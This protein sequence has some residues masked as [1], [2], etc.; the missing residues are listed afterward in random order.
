M[1]VLEQLLGLWHRKNKNRQ[2]IPANFLL[3]KAH[4]L[5]DFKNSNSKLIQKLC[6]FPIQ[7]F[8]RTF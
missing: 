5:Q 7:A 6:D 3:Y 2:E 8:L 4:F 1:M